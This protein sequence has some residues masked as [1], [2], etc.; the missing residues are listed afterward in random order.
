MRHLTGLKYKKRKRSGQNHIKNVVML[1]TLFYFTLLKNYY[2]SKLI[3]CK[4]IR[5]L[6]TTSACMNRKPVDRPS[7]IMFMPT[8]IIE[9]ASKRYTIACRFESLF[10]YYYLHNKISDLP[11]DGCS[12]RIVETCCILPTSHIYLYTL[13]NFGF[14]LYLQSVIVL[15]YLD[16]VSCR[17]GSP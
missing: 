12:Q 6:R 15:L 14:L 7:L 16:V 3:L 9:C 4:G 5:S 1:L 2:L 10:R 13:H 11:H 8:T 17:N